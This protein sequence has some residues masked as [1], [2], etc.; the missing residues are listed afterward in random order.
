MV[1]H[2]NGYNVLLGL[3]FKPKV[4]VNL[5]GLIPIS[6]NPNGFYSQRNHPS[7]VLFNVNKPS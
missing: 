7:N 5:L 1:T 3:V 2:N 6:E 4:C